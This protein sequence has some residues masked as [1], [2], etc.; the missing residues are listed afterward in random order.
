M[1]YIKYI[2]FGTLMGLAVSASLFLISQFP[3]R[4]LLVLAFGA[5][6]FWLLSFYFFIKKTRAWKEPLGVLT[7]LLFLSQL[8]VVL[9]LEHFWVRFFVILLSGAMFG[10][11]YGAGVSRGGLGPLQ[12]PYRRFVLFAWVW[13][14]FGICSTIFA[15][16]LFI[17]TPGL[18]VFLLLGGGIVMGLVP[19]FVWQ[20]YF[21]VAK[22]SFLLWM[23]IVGFV[24]MQLVWALHFLPLGYLTL[25]LLVTWA[26]YLL[27]LLARFHWDENGI[28]WK[29]QFPFLLTNVGIFVILVLFFVRWI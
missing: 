2:I 17:P 29:R 15:L 10:L 5:C 8:G 21:P 11:L 22:K 1:K 7:P 25:G 14:I 20:M 27:V 18:F 19:S 16:E 26:W 13:C 23:L 28:N 12:K 9:I 4:S 24:S 6:L 3:S